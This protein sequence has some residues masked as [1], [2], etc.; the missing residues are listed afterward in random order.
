LYDPVAE[1]DPPNSNSAQA[2]YFLRHFD[3]IVLARISRHEGCFRF[4]AQPAEKPPQMGSSAIGRCAS[5]AVQ[6]YAMLSI[7]TVLHP[8]DFSAY[9]KHAF[10]LACSLARDYGAR[11]LVLHVA[12]PPVIVYSEGLA[13]PP[14][15]T[16][17]KDQLLRQLR[18][19]Q[20]GDPK[21]QVEHRLVEGDAV[22]EILRAAGETKC[23]LIVMGTHGRT[24]LGRLLMG[25]VAER[26]M[27]KAA[28]PVVTVKT[29]FPET[30]AVH[31]PVT[32]SGHEA[33]GE[34]ERDHEA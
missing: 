16:Q 10:G 14:E 6:E 1:S 21:V 23:D 5:A 24:G 7:R 20:A 33:T 9:S 4:I 18:Q 2:L 19:V 30:C 22:A 29:P 27:R 11:L 17:Y 34:E 26:V 12:P 25:S 28:C 8:T 13:I 3:S 32:E 15:P 31:K